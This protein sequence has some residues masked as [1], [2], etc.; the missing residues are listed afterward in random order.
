M[1][2][3]VRSI[4]LLACAAAPTLAHSQE[5]S[6]TVTHDRIV[7]VMARHG[8]LASAAD[9]FVS[10]QDGVPILYHTVTRWVDSITAGMERNDPL[11]GSAT[12]RFANGRVRSASVRWHQGEKEVRAVTIEAIGD[13]LIVTDPVRRAFSTPRST[14]AI[15]DYGMDDLLVAALSSLSSGREHSVRVFR[16]YGAKWD[17]L[18]VRVSDRKGGRVL[19][20]VAA[21]GDTTTLVIADDGTLVHERRS[22]YPNN[23]RRPLEGTRAFALYRRFR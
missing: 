4:G 19:E 22:K 12:V 7:T 20:W 6:P 10:W 15:A 9:T 2:R 14:W 21:P 3:L 23:E 11:S 13:S 5:A 1:S 16:P 18:L 8:R 17:S